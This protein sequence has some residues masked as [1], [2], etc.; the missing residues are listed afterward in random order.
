PFSIETALAMTGAGARGKT[1]DEMEKV[2]HLPK[3]PHAV[4]G[5]LAAR[6]SGPVIREPRAYPLLGALP[7]G[8]DPVPGKRPY[9][10]SVANAIWA[11]KGFPWEKAFLDLTRK[12]YG[13][14]T[15]EVDFG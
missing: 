1:L 8:V 15:V 13:A 5:A 7:G 3:D 9:E 12:H 14:G 2:L 10:L 4:L 6:L 11:Q